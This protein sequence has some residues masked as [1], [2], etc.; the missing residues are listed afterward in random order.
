MQV[1]EEVLPAT[2]HQHDAVSK[3]NSNLDVDSS[4]LPAT[5]PQSIPRAASQSINGADTL[6]EVHA[7]HPAEKT[8]LLSTDD[9]TELPVTQPTRRR[10]SR[11]ISN[12]VE[13]SSASPVT[14]LPRKLI[15]RSITNVGQYSSHIAATVPTQK[16][17][18]QS[19]TTIEEFPQV[20][21]TPV[22]RNTR[23]LHERS[24]LR[25]A[26]VSGRTVRQSVA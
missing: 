10:V 12:V 24:A 9:V 5:P 1:L 15:S 26:T 7:I 22:M 13:H 19:I 2:T 17:A 16:T 18:S 25:P 6:S 21:E 3:S 4:K 11:S 23:N 8:G 14:T 20:P